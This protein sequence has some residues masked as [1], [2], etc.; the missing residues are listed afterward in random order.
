M[1]GRIKGGKTHLNQV[2]L[3]RAT[4]V[5]LE[6][7][8]NELTL[9]HTTNAVGEILL[10]FE[11]PLQ[12]FRLFFVEIGNERIGSESANPLVSRPDLRVRRRVSYRERGRLKEG[13]DELLVRSRT[14]EYFDSEFS[15]G[16]TPARCFV[17][18]NPALA[19][20]E[21]VHGYVDEVL[22]VELK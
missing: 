19:A 21:G 10:L 18:A 8:R 13:T 6:P 7:L 3:V 2:L 5:L 20:G 9:L 17:A 4:E 1:K 15:A 14:E 16:R 12:E 22:S 11:Y